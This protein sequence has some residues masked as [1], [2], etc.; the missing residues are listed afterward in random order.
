M[1]FPFFV[2]PDGP[3]A[4]S[5][6]AN[7]HHSTWPQSANLGPQIRRPAAIQSHMCYVKG[8]RLAGGPFLS[9]RLEGRHQSQLTLP[10]AYSP[11]PPGR[12]AEFSLAELSLTKEG[13]KRN[14]GDALTKVQPA[15]LISISIISNLRRQSWWQPG[16]N[17]LASKLPS[18]YSFRAGRAARKQTAA[19]ATRYWPAQLA[20]SL[21]CTGSSIL[22]AARKAGPR[23]DDKFLLPP[24]R[25][26]RKR[27]RLATCDSLGQR[28]LLAASARGASGAASCSGLVNVCI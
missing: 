14:S 7:V 20:G 13:R 5:P 10:S 22:Q 8:E 25:M 23:I 17:K 2:R 11:P 3:A 12:R 4:R 28:A 16:A 6:V 21:Q 1:H 26:Q 18:S 19:A 24:K 27:A 9:V 15:A